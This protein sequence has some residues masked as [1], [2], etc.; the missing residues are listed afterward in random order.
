MSTPYLNMEGVEPL[1]PTEFCGLGWKDFSWVT[2]VAWWMLRVEL[3]CLCCWI[4]RVTY[5]SHFD[6][7]SLFCVSTVKVYFFLLFLTLKWE[8]NEILSLS[9]ESYNFI[10]PPKHSNRHYYCRNYSDHSRVRVPLPMH[11]FLCTS[12]VGLSTGSVSLWSSVCQGSTRAVVLV[13]HHCSWS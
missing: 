5:N 12:S 13:T 7:S 4:H 9:S 8:K 3:N 6:K 1:Q 10:H 11:G 2:G